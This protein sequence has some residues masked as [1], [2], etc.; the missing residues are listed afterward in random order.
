MYNIYEWP[1]FIFIDK[2][3][4]QWMKIKILILTYWTEEITLTALISGQYA[5]GG[6]NTASR[7]FKKPRK[8]IVNIGLLWKLGWNNGKT[9]LFFTVNVRPK[10]SI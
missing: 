4:V 2:N 3:Y 8:Y 1:L 10:I 6:Y 7:S 9:T 5:K